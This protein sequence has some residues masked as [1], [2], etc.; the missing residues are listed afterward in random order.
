MVI[1]YPSPLWFIQQAFADRSCGS[2]YSVRRLRKYAGAAAG[3]ANFNKWTSTDAVGHKCGY[4]TPWY[5][6]LWQHLVGNARMNQWILGV[7]STFL[8]K[9]CQWSTIFF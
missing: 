6:I 4:F 2:H 9:P 3:K 7:E 5:E 8:V 1:I